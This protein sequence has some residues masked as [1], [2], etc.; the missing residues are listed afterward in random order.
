MYN[1]IKVQ[2]TFSCVL[3]EFFLFD[4]VRRFFVKGGFHMIIKINHRSEIPLYL[5]LRNQIVTGIGKGEL[6]PGESLP[7]VR[8]LAADLGINSMTVSK[9][10]QLLKT[11]GF[12][13]TDRRRGS[14]VSLPDASRPGVAAAFEEKLTDELELLTAEAKVHGMTL[15]DFLSFCTNAF[16]EMEVVS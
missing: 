12:L 2:T 14:V 1:T 6:K 15:Q 4:F 9:A 10:Y 11:E 3:S 5:Q 7:T 8:Q 16:L 13:E